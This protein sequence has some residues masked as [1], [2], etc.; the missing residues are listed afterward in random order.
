MTST[1]SLVNDAHLH[2][3][4]FIHPNSVANFRQ[5]FGELNIQGFDFTNRRK[6]SDVNGINE[7]NNF[8]ANKFQLSFYQ[9]ECE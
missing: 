1:E 6:S 7:M 5:H 2:P 8:S 4:E 9:I 3:R